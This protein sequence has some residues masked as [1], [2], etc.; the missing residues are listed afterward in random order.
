MIRS[1][2]S[3]LCLSVLKNRDQNDSETILYRSRPYERVKKMI[4]F[5]VE[6]YCESVKITDI[7]S[8]ANVSES[9]CLRC[10]QE[11]LRISPKAYLKK[12]RLKEAAKRLASS[13]KPV[14]QIAYETGF[15]HMSYFARSFA[16]EFGCTPVEYRKIQKSEP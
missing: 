2:F 1:C 6:K 15:S 3:R 8:S 9:E 5:I 13:S 10:F 11:I 4:S 7:A 16:A 14:T 12:Y